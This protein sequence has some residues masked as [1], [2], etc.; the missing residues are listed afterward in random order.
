MSAVGRS[1]WH[2]AGDNNYLLTHQKNADL[3][4]VNREVSG[5]L[6]LCA[7]GSGCVCC[8]RGSPSVGLVW[9]CPGPGGSARL[10]SCQAVP[11]DQLLRGASSLLSGL[12]LAILSFHFYDSI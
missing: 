7:G 11:R 5:V 9:H 2:T 1:A 8:W 4:V 10:C 12:L 3:F 6:E